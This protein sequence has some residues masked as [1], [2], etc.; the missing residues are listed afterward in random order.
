MFFPWFGNNVNTFSHTVGEVF[1]HTC[2][3]R[4]LYYTPRSPSQ[5]LRTLFLSKNMDWLRGNM[6]WF[7]ICAGSWIRRKLYS[8]YWLLSGAFCSAAQEWKTSKGNS[9]MFTQF[10]FLFLT[11]LNREKLF[12]CYRG[13]FTTVTSYRNVLK[14]RVLAETN[15]SLYLWLASPRREDRYCSTVGPS[16]VQ[17]TPPGLNK[18]PLLQGICILLSHMT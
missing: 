2:A 15:C 18:S 8:M 14:L 17:T 13:C 10:P 16:I 6:I 1:W 4:E 5:L 11:I 7:C 3:F 9:E 12:T